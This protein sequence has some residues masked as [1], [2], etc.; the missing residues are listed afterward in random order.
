MNYTQKQTDYIKA[1]YLESPSKET[2]RELA[3][4]LG[5]PYK[6][7]I[8]KLS[9][10]GVYRREEYRTKLGEKPK[11][12]IEMV[13]EIA[14]VLDVDPEQLLGLEKTPKLVLGL[15]N[16]LLQNKLATPS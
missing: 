4:E 2:C 7:I 6:S 14:L 9:K 13:A 15:L 3:A 1:R 8:G 10:E 12:K 5:K 11:T 16:K